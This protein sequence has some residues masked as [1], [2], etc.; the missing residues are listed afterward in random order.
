MKILVGIFL[1]AGFILK[2]KCK[3]I[4]RCKKIWH[5]KTLGRSLS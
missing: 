2:Y 5:E 4:W 3:K 1:L